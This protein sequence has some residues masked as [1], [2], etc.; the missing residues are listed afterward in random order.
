MRHSK[1]EDNHYL[2]VAFLVLLV[3]MKSQIHVPGS[4]IIGPKAQHQG[5]KLQQ[6]VCYFTKSIL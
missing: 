4:L 2:R 3:S 5:L 1:I 6:Y